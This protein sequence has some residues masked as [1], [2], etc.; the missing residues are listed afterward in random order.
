[1]VPDAR[2]VEVWARGPDGGWSFGS[3]YRVGPALVLT[4]A[5][6]VQPETGGPGTELF[7]RRLTEDRRWQVRT[8][9]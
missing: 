1:M 9:W 3:G 6:V 4:A 7:V 2:V 8:V 5:H